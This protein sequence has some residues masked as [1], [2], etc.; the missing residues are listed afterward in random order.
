MSHDL[1][2]SYAASEVAT[3]FLRN[4]DICF[5]NVP[6]RV[7]LSAYAAREGR[8]LWPHA[9]GVIELNVTG[10]ISANYSIALEFKRIN[11]GIHGVLTAIGQAHAYL[12]KGYAGSIIVIPEVY[13]G[14]AN[15]GAYVRQV[16]DLTSRNPAIG[17]FSYQPP[18]MLSPSPFAGKLILGRSLQVDAHPPVLATYAASATKTQWAHVR[19]GS[20]EPDAFFKYLQAIKLLSGGGLPPEKITIPQNLADAV[21][22]VRPGVKPEIYLSNAPRDGMTDRAWRYFWFKYILSAKVILGWKYDGTKYVVN[23]QPSGIIRSDGEGKKS[24][25]VGRRDSIKNKL[26]AGMNS[27]AINESD[28]L[29]KLVKNYHDRA[30]SYR[31]DIDSGAEHLGLIDGEGRLTAEGYRFVDACERTGDPNN[32]L[33]YS[34][35]ISCV[36]REGGLGAFLHYI[37]RLSEEKFTINPLEFTDQNKNKFDGKLYLQWVEDQMVNRLRVMRK[38]S[39][40]GGK[41]RLPFQA[42]LAL[43]RSIGLAGGFRTGVGL[44]INWPK[45]QDALEF[46]SSSIFLD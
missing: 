5:Q 7:N 10:R 23:D 26:V 38:V 28:A 34:I 6:D 35:F 30:H 1:E 37:Y 18:N 14:L 46:S 45:F 8:N 33:P 42:E 16:L 40:R 43:L 15:S 29:D 31:E 41:A 17:V 25:F 12:S 11:E 13:S 9:D 24:F 36:I 27:N 20:S 19:E 44:V 32:G 4:P 39:Q 21:E 22:R 3:E 2:A